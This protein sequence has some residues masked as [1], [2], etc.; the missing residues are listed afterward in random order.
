MPS[1]LDVGPPEIC[2]ETRG[3]A[4][5]EGARGGAASVKRPRR[6]LVAEFE[7][8]GGDRQLRAAIA[9]PECDA[10]EL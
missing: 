6:E 4:K 2:K 7:C 8:R 5:D 3:G 1:D 9:E 10:D